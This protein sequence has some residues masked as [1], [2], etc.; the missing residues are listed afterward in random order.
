M[1]ICVSLD[2]HS[3][4]SAG[5]RALIFLEIKILLFGLG[6]LAVFKK[7]KGQSAVICEVI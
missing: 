2:G 3:K 6:C 1:H 7:W 4:D 5:R